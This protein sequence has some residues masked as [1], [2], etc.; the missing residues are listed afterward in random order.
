MILTTGARLPTTVHSRT[1][2]LPWLQRLRPDHGVD[3]NPLDAGT[4]GIGQGDGVN[5]STRRGHMSLRANLT[6]AVPP[7]VVNIAHGN[8]QADVNLLI[9]PD[10]LD[11]V[12]GFPGFKSHLCEVQKNGTFL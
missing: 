7:G 1:N 10:Y 5:V 4:R 2:R 8:P 9:E 3:I 6:H 11:P 12:S